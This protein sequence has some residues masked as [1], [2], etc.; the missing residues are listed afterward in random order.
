MGMDWHSSGITTSVIGALKR[1]LNPRAHEL[2][3]Y[4]CGGRGRHSRNT[5]RELREV[6]A[7]IGRDGDALV[8]TSRLTA[9]I[10]N[11]AVDDGFQIY[12]HAFVVTPDGDWAVV[13]QGM[14]DASGLARRYHWHSAAVRDFVGRSAHGDRG[15]A[16]RPDPQP[17]GRPRRAGAA[18][19]A[20]DRADRSGPDPGRGPA[21][22]DARTPR[23]APRRRPRAAAWRGAGARPRAR[24]ARFR[25]LP[26]AR[27]ARAAHAAVAGAGRRSRAWRARAVRRSGALLVRP[28]RQGRS[29]LPG[30]A[31][32]VRRV[33]R[34]A[35]AGARCRQ[36]R[37]HAIVSRDS[38][39]S[40]RSRALSNIA[41]NR[42]PTWRP[43]SLTSAP[44]RGRSAAAPYWTTR[45]KGG[46]RRA[47]GSCRCSKSLAARR[48]DKP[49]ASTVM[50][51]EHSS[52]G[53]F[54]PA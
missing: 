4:I 26:A 13:Q 25:L 1:G 37:A 38:P 49:W 23:C 41:G 10:D 47:R 22:R 45:G 12:L 17:R 51:A 8:R 6:A 24:P 7:R 52:T 48:R 35:A 11:N 15:R 20:D 33:D 14:N 32:G 40:T 16:R 9:R 39:G 29:P 36:A 54:S 18:G 34:G 27:T 28:R 53:G 3:I 19:A 43:P 5:P 50:S 21:A 46:R 42:L 44:S 31:D 2:G 30:P